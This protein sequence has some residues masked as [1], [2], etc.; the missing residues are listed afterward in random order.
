M[1]NFTDEKSANKWFECEKEINI[2][3]TKMI[4]LYA[5]IFIILFGLIGHFLT[6][7]VFSQ[8]RFR[9]NSTNIYSFVLA[10]VDSLFLLIHFGED[11]IRTYIDVNFIESYNS[12]FFHFILTINLTGKY[13]VV[14]ITIQYLRYVLRFISAYIICCFTFQRLTI[15]YCPL[16][17]NF[18]SKK[19]A[20]KIVLFVTIVSFLVNFWALFLF[21]INTDGMINYCDVKKEW[22]REY[23]HITF[24]YIFLIIL[25]PILVIFVS[26][27]IIIAKSPNVNQRQLNQTIKARKYRNQSVSR[28]NRTTMSRHHSDT[29]Y[30]KLRPIFLNVNQLLNKAKLKEDNSKKLTKNLIL[31]SFSYAFCNLPFLISWIFFYYESEYTENNSNCLYSIVKICEIFYL[32]N[33]SINFYVNLA[34]ASTFKK[35]LKYS[36]LAI[37]LD[38]FYFS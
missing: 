29:N 10:I 20:W 27:T 15:V 7:L 31:I 30:C 24:G 19:S 38:S 8:H 12:N 32:L 26:N 18:K 33:Y 1:E 2:N 22:V 17:I 9:N 5:S 14:C 16:T 13:N 25:L 36:G 34:F 35:Q 11:T 6:I 37:Y 23:F 28:M 21:E 3:I 4:N